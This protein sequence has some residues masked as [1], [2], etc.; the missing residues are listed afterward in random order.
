MVLKATL[1]GINLTVYY[2]LLASA[3]GIELKC[4]SYLGKIYHYN[5]I[6]VVKIWFASVWTIFIFSKFPK[7]RDPKNVEHT[8][9]LPSNFIGQLRNLVF[10]FRVMLP[11]NFQ[12]WLTF[13][14]K[15]S[16][17]PGY[18]LTIIQLFHLHNIFKE[19]NWTDEVYKEEKKRLKIW[20]QPP[21]W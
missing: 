18:I 17:R 6:V 8:Q 11:G 16:I 2:C 10:L 15:V 13:Y 4:F 19:Y 3:W 21:E 14:H 1:L 5:Y 12:Q 7:S 20:Q 9:L